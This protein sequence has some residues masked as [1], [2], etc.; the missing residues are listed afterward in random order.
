VA[1]GDTQL[2]RAWA[3][4]A[5][6]GRASAAGIGHF[7]SSRQPHR[8]RWGRILIAHQAP[9]RSRGRQGRRTNPSG[10]GSERTRDPQDSGLCGHLRQLRAA[11]CGDHARSGPASSTSRSI[12]SIAAPRLHVTRGAEGRP[13]RS[14]RRAGPSRWDT[15]RAGR[16]RNR[17]R[18]ARGFRDGAP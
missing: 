11:R 18:H 4:R 10:A 14:A 9:G 16:C 6:Q 17:P 1:G 13:S 15:R 12:A 2:M 3:R 8:R 5:G 7:R